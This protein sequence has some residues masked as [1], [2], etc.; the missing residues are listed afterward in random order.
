MP[1]EFETFSDIHVTP[2]SEDNKRKYDAYDTY[3]QRYN[4]DDEGSGTVNDVESSDTHDRN[5]DS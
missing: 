1:K 3:G 2:F 4:N 5:L